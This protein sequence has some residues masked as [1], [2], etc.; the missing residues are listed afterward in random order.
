[1]IH[2]TNPENLE[3]RFCAIVV[4]IVV[5]IISGCCCTIYLF[6]TQ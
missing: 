3:Q 6:I 2:V 1:M 5:V 4:F